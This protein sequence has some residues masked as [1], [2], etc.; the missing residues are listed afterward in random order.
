[1]K[2]SALATIAFGVELAL[3]A[4][5]TEKRRAGHA[6]RAASRR[7]NPR[8]PA[9]GSDGIEI[10]SAVNGTN[11]EYSSNWAGA[12]LIGTGYTS[13]TGTFTVPTPS[14]PSG[15]SSGTEASYF[16]TPPLRDTRIPSWESGPF[17]SQKYADSGRHSTPPPLGLASMATLPQTPFSRLESTFTSRAVKSHTTL[18][19]SGTQ[20][21]RKPPLLR[22]HLEVLLR[23]N[24]TNCL[25]YSYDFS[26]ISISAGDTITVTVTATSTTAGTAVVENVTK[27]TSVTHTFSGQS[28]ALQELNAEWI[29]EDFSEG[30]SLVPFADFGKV[31]FTSATAVGSS[32]TVTPSGATIIDIEQDGEVLTSSSAS[33]SS[34]IVEYVG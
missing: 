3:A 15:G 26:G 24:E 11:E 14:T 28:E 25:V 32:G 12:V 27:G 4:R 34:V 18:G 23:R 19:T 16:P 22:R 21:T 2:F 31:T 13:V 20:T 9:T 1:M 33:S 17:S 30:Y 29:V 10:D 6:A 7:S 8:L 5:F